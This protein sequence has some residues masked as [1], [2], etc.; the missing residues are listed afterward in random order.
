MQTIRIGLVEDNAS[1]R[2][3]F[4]ENM[5][6]F[7]QVQLVLVAVNGLDF[8]KKIQ[9]MP[10]AE[11]P[12]IVLTDIEMDGMDGIQ[13]V[14]QGHEFYPDIQFIML[15]VFDNDEKIFESIQAGAMGYMLKDEHPEKIVEAIEDVAQGGAPMSPSIARRALQLLRNAKAPVAPAVPSG[16]ASTPV[17]DLLSRREL[18]I[19]EMIV[20]GLTYQ[21]IA[22]K[23]FISPH[24]VRTHI[25]HIYE[26]LHVHSK[27][28]IIHMAIEKKWFSFKNR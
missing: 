22:E 2:R 6:Y 26:K 28:A 13:T 1:L 23:T 8:L 20:E 16:A 15:T 3:S 18:E 5:Q 21:Q 24:T 19:M 25:Q 4:I 17:E 10:L 27:A 11:R 9:E 12:Q 14:A 7:E